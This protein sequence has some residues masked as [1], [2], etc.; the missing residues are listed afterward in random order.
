MA[1]TTDVLKT[2]FE[3]EDRLTSK[4]DQIEKKFGSMERG[5]KRL[6]VS[7]TSLFSVGA[8][9]AGAGTL[10]K[11]ILDVTNS[12]EQYRARLQTILG[13]QKAVNDALRFLQDF[14][15][16][17]PYTLDEVTDAFVRMSA[18]GLQ[19]TAQRFKTIGDFAASMGRTF[20]DAV[21]AIADAT[22]GEFE[23]M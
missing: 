23:R 9:A 3:V 6:H 22:H 16:D 5:A 18:Y 14:A 2:V 7:L 8:A 12:F 13:T 17:T 4:L 11:S 10:A 15:Q 1:T 21:E 20:S 19:P